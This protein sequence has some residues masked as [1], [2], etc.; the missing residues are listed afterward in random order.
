MNLH[1]LCP[2][3][4]A[5][6]LLSRRQKPIAARCVEKPVTVINS[7]FLPV[8]H[9][10]TRQE[11]NSKLFELEYFSTSYGH[12]YVSDNSSELIP[13]MSIPKTM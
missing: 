10:L 9:L 5:V 13:D 6:L 12:W 1:L 2:A 7:T 4:S 3:Y 11:A 8:I